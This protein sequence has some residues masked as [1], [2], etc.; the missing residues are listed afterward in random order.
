MHI[1]IYTVKW[2]ILTAHWMYNAGWFVISLAEFHLGYVKGP[3]LADCHF[4]WNYNSLLCGH[5][6]SLMSNIRAVCS[7]S[8]LYN[9]CSYTSL[10]CC[11]W[12]VLYL[13]WYSLC[14]TDCFKLSIDNLFT[15]CLYYCK[16]YYNSGC[17]FRSVMRHIY[18]WVKGP[19]IL[20]Q[21]QSE[22][23]RLCVSSNLVMR[24]MCLKMILYTMFMTILFPNYSTIQAYV[25]SI[26]EPLKNHHWG[27]QWII[28]VSY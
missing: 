11:F 13:L 5:Y 19:C 21:R 9:T 28:S 23:S 15:L 24:I 26:T 7:L 1:C 14:L 3:N 18:L 2:S 8:S 20:W 16:I 6:L 12:L 22:N 10:T 25:E 27:G 4:S 17:I